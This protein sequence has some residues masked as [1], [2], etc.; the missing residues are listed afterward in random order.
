MPDTAHSV[1]PYR[2]CIIAVK[3]ERAVYA[4]KNDMDMYQGTPWGPWIPLA[5]GSYDTTK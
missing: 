3:Y 1:V 2:V 4:P 5:Y